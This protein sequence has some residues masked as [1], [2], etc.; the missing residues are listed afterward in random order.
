MH[1]SIDFQA[2]VALDDASVLEILRLAQALHDAVPIAKV[3]LSQDAPGTYEY[4]IEAVDGRVW[5]QAI[6]F[7]ASPDND[8]PMTF[9]VPEGWRRVKEFQHH[10]ALR[11]HLIKMVNAGLTALE[12]VW[13]P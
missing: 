13:H 1:R 11:D 6:T 2:T 12:I 4:K 9:D 3:E 5:T 7:T 10:R 8:P